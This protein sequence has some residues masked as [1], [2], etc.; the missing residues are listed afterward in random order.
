MAF[1]EA[2]QYRDFRSVSG[3]GLLAIAPD[4]ELDP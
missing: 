3:G 2:V 1:G 4:P